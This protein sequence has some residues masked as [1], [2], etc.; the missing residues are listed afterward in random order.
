MS[1]DL[2]VS[3]AGVCTHLWWTKTL[4][5]YTKRVVLVNASQG[6]TI[7]GHDIHRHVA[8]LRV[9]S[10]DIVRRESPALP[11]LVNG[12][13]EIPLD[14]TRLR[15]E[16]TATTDVQRDNSFLS[17]I[18]RLS[19]LTPGLPAPSKEAVDDGDPARTACIFELTGGTLFGRSNDNGAALAELQASTTDVPHLSITWAATQQRIDL[20]LRPGAS[21][22]VS[23]VGETE[24]HD[25]EFDFL[26]HYKLAAEMPTNPQVLRDRT[27]CVT[28]NGDKTW[29][30]G[31]RSVGPGCS[32]SAYP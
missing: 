25:D 23:N 21:I 7:D 28:A 2:T 31:F 4:P 19:M 12:I 18:P 11:E 13:V 30:P 1:T 26:L 20:Y 27:T 9:A 10:E 8:L 3:F 32:N 22:T 5:S 24:A 17:C 16:N 29:P 15:L 6:E 14:G